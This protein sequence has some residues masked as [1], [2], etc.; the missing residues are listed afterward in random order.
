VAH[1]ILFSQISFLNLYSMELLLLKVELDFLII[2]LISYSNFVLDM[3]SVETVVILKIP[4]S[5]FLDFSP[6]IVY[7]TTNKGQS[8]QRRISP[9]P[10]EFWA[11][12]L[13]QGDLVA[14]AM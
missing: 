8:V 13:I 10:E 9:D 2:L 12:E 11:T 1:V 7:Q 4:D 6:L 14:K 5:K 3:S